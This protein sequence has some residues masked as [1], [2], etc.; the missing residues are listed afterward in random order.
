MKISELNSA[1][2]TP[3][4]KWIYLCFFLSGMDA[5]IY[6]VSW[7]NRIQL[8]MGH[9]IYS[10]ATTLAAYMT[11]LALG[12]L[13]VPRLKKTGIHPLAL[14]LGAE[15]LI[16]LYGLAFYPLLKLTQI[17]YDL[18][19]SHFHFSLFAISLIQFI[20]CTFIVLIPTFLMGTTLPLIGPI[21]YPNPN[22]ISEKIPTLY[23]FNTLGAM[24]GSFA[25]G[26]IILPSLGYA[27]TIQLA[28]GI[29]IA[30]YF[31]VTF[32]A[33]LDESTNRTLHKTP[34]IQ[35]L[36]HCF[37]LIC[38]SLFSSQK[39]I[40]IRLESR[41]QWGLLVLFVSGLASMLTQV[42]WNRL[43]ALGF[44]PT[45][46]IFSLITTVVLAGIVIGST[47]WRRLSVDHEKS[48]R[49]FILLP[50]LASGSVLLGNYAF[51]QT[52]KIVLYWNQ[53]FNPEFWL[54]TFFELSWALICLLPSATC[55][56]ALFPAALSQ[57]T[58]NQNT[59]EATST[60]SIGYAV[61]IAGLMTGALL[62]SF[63]LLP[64][65]GVEK[66]SQCLVML[67][68]T[69]SAALAIGTAGLY[70]AAA[71]TFLLGWIGVSVVPSF[72]WNLLTSG[73]FYNRNRKVN[74]ETLRD[75][76]WL[77]AVPYLSMRAPLIAI[78]DDPH[79]TISIH[80]GKLDKNYRSFK[81]NGKVD[82]TN[83]SDLRTTRLLSAY[84]AMVKADA[85]S[86]LI[87]GLGTGSTA[88][89]TLRYPS[90]EKVKVIELSSA[91]VEFAQKYFNTVDGDIWNDPRF[92]IEHRDGRDY[93]DHSPETFDLIISEPSNP[94]VEGVGSL[95]T[96]EFYTSLAKRLK[97]DGVASLW[98]HSYGL[99]CQAVQSV[100][101]AV[102]AVFQSMLVFSQ[103]G[104]IFILAA[105]NPDGLNLK[106]IPTEATRHAQILF[107]E[108]GITQAT[109]TADAYR[110]LFEKTLIYDRES[111]LNFSFLAP[112]NLDDNQFLQYRSGQTYS[113]GINCRDFPGASSPE[114]IQ[115]YA[116]KFFSPN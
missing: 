88:A 9:S 115:R 62:G 77:S 15:V 53:T 21:I 73:Y 72:D 41:Q 85:H 61:N 87:I 81:V 76:G 58:R 39:T 10:L 68:F 40:P 48:Q 51:S 3:L 27:K 36:R 107:E 42:T 26:Y 82:G 94:W 80:Q 86:A 56:G 105:V 74:S 65:L 116:L 33:N 102:G 8:V 83:S 90:M 106:S 50:L 111:A 5:L 45:T 84:P 92:S 11:G 98:F 49:L 103:G 96:Q 47:L 52:P 14:Y 109:S 97:P 57:L 55:I 12:A 108:N 66:I 95:F 31:M 100:L 38:K 54:K 37:I 35:T 93:L 19:V 67:L 64:Y 112:V 101:S 99:D 34:S 1:S 60:L 17:P 113:T 16:G 32:L 13:Y 71:A 91:M 18:L 43:A 69:L 20:F 89:Q 7:L 70:Q 4:Q 114:M 30:L 29:N 22:E 2:V 75:S 24:I 6:E 78:K 44:G 59:E 46:Y 25:T 28:A 79:A 110:Q 104:D 63:I 23:A